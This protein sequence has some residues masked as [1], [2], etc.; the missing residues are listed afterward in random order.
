MNRDEREALKQTIDAVDRLM[1]V[2][3]IERALYLVVAFVSFLMLIYGSV[4]LLREPSID[5]T[6]ITLIL[7]GNGLATVA[8]TRV[9]YFLNRA[10]NLVEQLVRKFSGIT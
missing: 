5:P 4:R 2:F 1:S 8:A 9:A 7:G 3:K 6:A 10:F